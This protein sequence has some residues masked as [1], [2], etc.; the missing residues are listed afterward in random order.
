M[1]KIAHIINPVNAPAGSELARVQPVTFASI[2]RAMQE[3]EGKVNVKF[4]TAQFAEDHP[5]VPSWAEKTPD[6]ERSLMDFGT[7]GRTRKL[8]VLKDILDR[9][10]AASDA[11]YFVYSNADICL[12]PSFYNV[13]DAYASKGYDAFAI[14]RRRITNRFTSPEELELMYAEAGEK[15]PGY[16]TL[17]FRRDLYPKFSLG[18]VCVGIPFFDTVLI[19]NF[20]A[21]AQQF[22]LFTGK[23]LTFHLGMELIRQWGDA[24]HY[25]HNAKEYRAVRKEL[26]PLFRIENFPGANLPFFVRHFKW[27]FN[28]TFHYPTMLRLDFSQLGRKRRPRKKREV[29]GMRNRYFEFMSRHI[30]FDDEF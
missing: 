18:N 26:Y 19:H 22:R 16:D 23:H 11:E 28:P 1:R 12:M 20:Y 10:Y 9:L 2:R 29:K 3:A 13:I 4:F 21:H 24:D 17:V 25:R 27:L 30:N 8:P 5:V 15:H 14:N 7:F 6:L